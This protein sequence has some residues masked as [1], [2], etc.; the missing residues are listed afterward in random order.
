M[1]AHI[2]NAPHTAHD[3]KAGMLA[4]NIFFI[5]LRLKNTASSKALTLRG[6][7]KNTYDHK[8]VINDILMKRPVWSLFYLRCGIVGRHLN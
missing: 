4:K 6:E 3:N 8:M 7:V 5:C 1:T 2:I